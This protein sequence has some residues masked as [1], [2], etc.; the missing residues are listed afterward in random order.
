[1]LPSLSLLHKL[2]LTFLQTS[3]RCHQFLPE[4]KR[5]Q[6]QNTSSLHLCRDFLLNPTAKSQRQ[7]AQLCSSYLV[8]NLD[9]ISCLPAGRFSALLLQIGQLCNH[10]CYDWI[11]QAALHIR[12]SSVSLQPCAPHVSVNRG[13]TPS[14][15]KYK[16]F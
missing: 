9:Y 14:V 12:S 15:S 5:Q 6:L 10:C 3:N 11:H 4:G 13:S 7:M 8:T 2:P 16:M 1:M